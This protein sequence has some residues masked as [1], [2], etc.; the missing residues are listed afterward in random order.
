M[1]TRGIRN[2]NPGN[3]RRVA[4]WRGLSPVQDDAE[5]CR[6]IQ[7][8]YGLRAMSVILRTYTRRRGIVTLEGVAARWAPT[9]EN[10]TPSYLRVLCDR[11]EVGPT[12]P[13]P[14][15]TVIIPALVYAENGVQPYEDCEI[16]DAVILA[17]A[18]G[19]EDDR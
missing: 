18:H 8:I 14:G 9:S 4:A 16:E 11:C 13:L 1:T 12:D 19:P 3:I 2:N 10:D 15:H 5:F 17:L 6:F 7:P